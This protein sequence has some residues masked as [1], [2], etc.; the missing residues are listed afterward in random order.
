MTL[1]EEVGKALAEVKKTYEINIEKE[2]EKNKEKEDVVPIKSKKFTKQSVKEQK[3]K[4]KHLEK[5][6]MKK[7]KK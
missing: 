2:K 7:M 1:K 3:K 5:I 6:M 4:L